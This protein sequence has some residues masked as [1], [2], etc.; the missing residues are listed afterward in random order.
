MVGHEY[1]RFGHE[2]DITV[3]AAQV[4]HVLSL[5]I[6]AVAP[7]VDA[8][9]QLVVAPQDQLC[10]VELGI[11]VGTLREAGILSVHPHHSGTIE[12]VEM[13]EHALAIPVLWQTEG[14]AI[15]AC[16]VVIG[17]PIF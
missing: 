11:G 7:T 15:E 6:A 3:D 17:D 2:I 12:T 10:D 14:A 9:R 13:E 16:S 5:K 4:P 1:L 8:H